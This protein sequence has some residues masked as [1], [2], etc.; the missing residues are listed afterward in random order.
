MN[1][2]KTP[3]WVITYRLKHG[4]KQYRLISDGNTGIEAFNNFEKTFPHIT[5]NM[6]Y[7]NAVINNASLWH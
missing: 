2:I 4:R 6:V 5:D 7:I 1:K 3:D